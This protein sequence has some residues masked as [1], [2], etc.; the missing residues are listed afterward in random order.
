MIDGE[1]HRVSSELRKLK[2]DGRGETNLNHGFTW[3][4]ASIVFPD[5]CDRPRDAVLQDLI[6]RLADLIAPEP[7]RTCKWVWCEDW[8]DTPAGPRELICAN[9]HLDCGCWDGEDQ[10]LRNL[11]DQY[12]RPTMWLYC[13]RCGAKVVDDAH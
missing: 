6:D 10:D 9:W 7:E 12:E 1:K 5:L 8:V 13:P 11:S 2:I 3:S 4:V